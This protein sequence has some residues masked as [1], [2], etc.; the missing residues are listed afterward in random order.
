MTTSTLG[1]VQATPIQPPVVGL[2]ASLG[3]PG[4][5][6][7]DPPDTFD[8]FTLPAFNP[9]RP[10]PQPPQAPL[11]PSGRQVAL[12]ALRWEAGYQYLPEQTCL[13]TGVSDPCNAA[14]SSIPANPDVV[15]VEPMLVWAGDKCSPFGWEAHDFVGRATRAL[16]ATESKLIAAELWK[17]TQAK[18]SGWDNHYLAADAYA[19]TLSTSPVSPTTALDCLEQGLADCGNGMRGV[20]HCTRQLGSFW[21]SL[22][23]TF[24]SVNGQIVT[25]M[26]TVIIPD[27]G[28][29]G[30]G[31]Q[32]Q[33][34]VDGSQWAYAT[35]MPTVRR[36]PVEVIPGSFA[37]ALTKTTNLLEWRATRLA[38]VSYPSCCQLA[39]EINLPICAE[40]GAS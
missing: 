2:I 31:P 7:L 30:S 25:Y 38:T 17:G 8:P 32:G 9:D 15:K 24:R 34:R 10:A 11:S 40:G 1:V 27:A 22:G 16:L 12:E 35:L 18:T 13:A 4:G 21:S 19:D 37:E 6:Y 26:G 14:L 39:V 29:D 20:I 33:P 28:Y 5:P 36:S 3:P 23:Q